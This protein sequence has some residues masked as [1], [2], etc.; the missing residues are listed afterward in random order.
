MTFS[1][2]PKCFLEG[3]FQ[4]QGNIPYTVPLALNVTFSWCPKDNVSYIYVLKTLNCCPWMK[5]AIPLPCPHVP[6]LCPCDGPLGSLRGALP[7]LLQLSFSASFLVVP[8]AS[9]SLLNS[10]HKLRWPPYFIQLFVFSRAS[11]SF[12]CLRRLSSLVSGFI[13]TLFR[14]L[15]HLGRSRCRTLLWM[16]RVWRGH[17]LVCCYLCYYIGTCLSIRS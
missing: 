5:I 14:F 2:P 12:V 7:H 13:V 11:F 6:S 17:V 9:L 4:F 3:L 16:G 1:S 10:I 8:G 15:F